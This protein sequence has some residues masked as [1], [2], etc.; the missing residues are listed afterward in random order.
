VQLLRYRRSKENKMLKWVGSEIAAQV[1]LKTNC[2]HCGT[3]VIIEEFL[4]NGCWRCG[5]K[6]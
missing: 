2:P 6:E 5:Y 4:E 1:E 3:L